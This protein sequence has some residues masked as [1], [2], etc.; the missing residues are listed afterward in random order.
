M[1]FCPR[2][3]D[4][5]VGGEDS[6]SQADLPHFGRPWL[7]EGWCRCAR[8][9]R[10]RE[11]WAPCPS[12]FRGLLRPGCGAP[13]QRGG[14]G[15]VPV[16]ADGHTRGGAAQVIFLCHGDH[17]SEEPPL[18][19]P[20][21]HLEPAAEHWDQV[22]RSESPRCL[23][24]S[25]QTPAVTPATGSPGPSTWVCHP[26]YSAGPCV[27]RGWEPGDPIM[28]LAHRGPTLGTDS[29]APF[30]YPWGLESGRS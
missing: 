28:V 27:A 3:R 18:L 17:V 29:E 2:L 11:T 23:R 9:A 25:E 14:P 8:L 16:L 20:Q 7:R 10:P 13:A 12:H 1:F 6:A 5:V 21:E 4:L 30:S 22:P 19:L 26:R 15:Q 24:V